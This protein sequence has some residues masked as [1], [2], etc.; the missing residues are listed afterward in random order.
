MFMSPASEAGF[1]EPTVAEC[2][3]QQIT[4]LT[5]GIYRVQ[6]LLNAPLK[7]LAG[8]YL[9]L[10]LDE[11]AVPY[12]I[13]S[14]PGQLPMLELQIQDQG[15]ESLSSQVIRHFKTESRVQVRL[16]MGDCYLD[17]PPVR[18][19]QPLIFIA[20][21]TGF[22]QMKALIEHALAEQMSNPLHLYW[23]VREAE[24]LYGHELIK[25]WQQCH[26]QFHFHPVVS[27]VGIGDWSGRI[28][29]VHNSVLE[30]FERLDNAQ[31]YVCGSPA[32]VYAVED[33][34]R[35]RGMGDGQMHA[36]VYSYAPRG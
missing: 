24:H 6:L 3:V 9:E 11:Q 4:L 20:A 17:Q 28:G 16:P 26:P 8:Q 10:L 35:L 2:L 1:T 32:M 25:H 15:E 30:D 19:D 18:A 36:D 34:F 13:A 27:A 21:G 22:A 5:D 7:H 12:T 29:L 23:G 31:I 14:A 33:D